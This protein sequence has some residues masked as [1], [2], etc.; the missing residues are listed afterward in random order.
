MSEPILAGF[1]RVDI[2]P[3]RDDPAT[4]EVLDPIYFWALHV[5]KRVTNTLLHHTGKTGKLS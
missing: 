4:F 2:T 5:F 1:G 3:E